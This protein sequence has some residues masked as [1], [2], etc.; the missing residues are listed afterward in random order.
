MKKRLIETLKKLVQYNLITYTICN[1]KLKRAHI[2][3]TSL[4]ILKN[5]NEIYVNII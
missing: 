4:I 3:F 2:I 1:Q 5:Y